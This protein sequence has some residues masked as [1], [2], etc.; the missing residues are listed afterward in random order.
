MRIGELAAVVGVTTRTIRHYHRIGLLPEPERRSNGYRDYSLRDAVEL[1]RVRRLTELGLSLDEVADAVA[2]DAGR[3]LVDI[4]RELDA[5]LERQE[6]AIRGRRARLAQLLRRAEQG[7]TAASRIPVSAE[8]ADLFDRMEQVSTALPGPEPVTA[9]K[10]REL[11][12]LLETGSPAGASGWF[13]ALTQALKS[14]GD[15]MD[16]A[17]AVYAR[18][19]ELADADEDDPRVESTARAVVEAMPASA[20]AAISLPDRAVPEASYGFAEAF[21][22]DHSPAQAAV[23][24]R[25]GELIRQASAAGKPEGDPS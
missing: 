7:G 14:D 25:A 4:L 3:E 16:R 24:R 17:Y 2:D 19:D 6:D 21:L 20:I 23:I 5:D 22:A 12:A 1:A 15:A 8:L 13:T 18:L 10:E 9:G 11:M